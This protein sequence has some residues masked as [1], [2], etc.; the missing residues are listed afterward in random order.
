MEGADESRNTG[1]T[2]STYASQA[3]ALNPMGTLRPPAATA[4]QRTT[5]LHPAP[6]PDKKM[7]RQTPKRG[8]LGTPRERLNGGFRRRISF[9]SS[10]GEDSPCRTRSSKVSRILTPE[11]K[12]RFIKCLVQPRAVRSL[13]SADGSC[14]STEPPLSSERSSDMSIKQV[15]RE[16]SRDFTDDG[17]PPSPRPKDQLQ[18]CVEHSKQMLVWDEW[19]NGTGTDY[20]IASISY[21]RVESQN[22][23]AAMPKALKPPTTEDLEG[24]ETE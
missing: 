13:L 16:V 9:G 17:R 23:I 1:N 3:T 5:Q 8:R 6:F 20:D 22:I 24:D 14:T 19:V 10:S 12:S 7:D 11:G 15:L 4:K 18:N 2:G 21:K